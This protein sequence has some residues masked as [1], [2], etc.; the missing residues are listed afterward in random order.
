[1]TTRPAPLPAD[2]EAEVIELLA[3]ALLADLVTRP[4]RAEGNGVAPV[5]V[6]PPR[7]RNRG[8]VAPVSRVR[9]GRRLARV[10]V[11]PKAPG[12]HA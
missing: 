7:G 1:M 12:S 8:P 4:N 11:A 5:T 6:V 3:R 10:E 2:L 9:R